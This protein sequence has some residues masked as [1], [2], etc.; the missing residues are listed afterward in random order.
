MCNIMNGLTSMIIDVKPFIILHIDARYGKK[1][2]L[3]ILTVEILYD[4]QVFW[5]LEHDSRT[6]DK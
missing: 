3:S 4:E 2:S 1:Y 6:I 5:C